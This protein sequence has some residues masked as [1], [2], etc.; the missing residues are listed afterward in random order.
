MRILFVIRMHRRQHE[1]DSEGHT[2]KQPGWAVQGPICRMYPK[3]NLR[4]I[5]DTGYTYLLSFHE[6][7][8]NGKP[9]SVPS[10]GR[11]FES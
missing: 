10:G 9:S 6:N 4:N 5:E 11:E 8:L 1:P 2:L 3:N 7:C